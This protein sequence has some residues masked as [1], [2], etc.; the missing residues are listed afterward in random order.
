MQ[1]LG[2]QQLKAICR[3]LTEVYPLA[4][5]SCRWSQI[6][7]LKLVQA[8][9]RQD[10][11][12]LVDLS[13]PRS[14][15][16]RFSLCHWSLQKCLRHLLFPRRLEVL[17]IGLLA[18]NLKGRPQVG[19][20]LAVLLLAVLLLAGLATHR[21]RCCRG[22]QFTCFLRTSSPQFLESWV[23]I[24]LQASFKPMVSLCLLLPVHDQQFWQR[25]LSQAELPSCYQSFHHPLHPVFAGLLRH[26]KFSLSQAGL[27]MSEQESRVV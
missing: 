17:L 20:L 9:S 1:V 16:Q 10:P 2:C 8:L 5:A 3:N 25:H 18:L 23:Q 14:R 19:L 11:L 26:F 13:H 12:Q 21:L 27:R 7:R 4:P 24:A 22:C 6:I 15:C